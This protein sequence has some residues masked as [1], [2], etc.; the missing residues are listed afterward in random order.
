MWFFYLITASLHKEKYFN[1]FQNKNKLLSFKF[2][3]QSLFM[4]IIKKRKIVDS[5]LFFEAFYKCTTIIKS[6]T[7]KQNIL[8][9]G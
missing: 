3:S 6:V 7:F 8:K 4:F 9:N 2:S 5:S 1:S